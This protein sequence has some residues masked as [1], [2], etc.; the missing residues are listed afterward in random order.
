MS[1]YDGNGE[2]DPF[3]GHQMTTVMDG[4]CQGRCQPLHMS[5]PRTESAN[6]KRWIA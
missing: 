2:A 1:P 5:A 6:G 4:Q 3:H